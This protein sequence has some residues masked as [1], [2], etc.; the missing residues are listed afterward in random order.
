MTTTF[1]ATPTPVEGARIVATV[2]PDAVRLAIG[3]GPP[4]PKRGGCGCGPPA[5][6]PRAKPEG[7]AKGYPSLAKQALNLAGSAARAAKAAAA[8]EQVMAEPAVRMKRLSVC[9]TC[10]TYDP[11]QG[12][13]RS[14]GC[15][16][17]MKARMAS[18]SCPENR[19]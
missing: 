18:E 17:A 15:F 19:W 16:V 9:M 3:E 13:C 8:G 4:A 1:D 5:G 2:G 14:C 12:R 10:P 11:S 7:P 6:M